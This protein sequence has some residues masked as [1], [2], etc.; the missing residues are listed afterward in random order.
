MTRLGGRRQ[1]SVSCESDAPMRAE[2]APLCLV[3]PGEALVRGATIKAGSA[4]NGRWSFV[5]APLGV[6]ICDIVGLGAKSQMR[7]IAAWRIVAL[8]QHL[9]A[10][11][12]GAVDQG[13][14][15]HVAAPWPI[16]I[17]ERSV[18]VDRHVRLIPWPAVVW[19]SLQN[20]RPEVRGSVAE[21]GS[22]AARART[23]NIGDLF[24][25]PLRPHCDRAAAWAWMCD[26]RRVLTKPL[27][28]LRKWHDLLI[29]RPIGTLSAVF[30]ERKHG[31]FI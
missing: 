31:A 11:W 16:L 17:A 23:V 24:K 8:V 9:H 20:A 12:N 1:P 14:S 3:V 26:A 21:L 18:S 28:S 7:R 22:N 29:I 10:R 15:E 25:K 27:V 30:S 4:K 6:H 13:P 5:S 19:P 2:L